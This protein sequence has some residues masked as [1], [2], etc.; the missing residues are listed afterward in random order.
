MVVQRKLW[1]FQY[2]RSV[3][4][5]EFSILYEFGQRLEFKHMK[6]YTVYSFYRE[7]RKLSKAET[8]GTTKRRIEL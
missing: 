6:K 1:V 4:P 7:Y 8:S 5:F 3:S 2:S